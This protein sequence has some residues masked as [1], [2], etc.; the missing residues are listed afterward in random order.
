MIGEPIDADEVLAVIVE[1]QRVAVEEDFNGER[2]EED[3]G[4]DAHETGVECFA[5]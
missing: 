3:G 4:D 5:Q 1:Q 2:D